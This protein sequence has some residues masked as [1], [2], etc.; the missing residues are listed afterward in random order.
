MKLI[1]T[2]LRMA[3]QNPPSPVRH[4]WCGPFWTV[5]ELENGRTG[6]CATQLENRGTHGEHP[7]FTR[8]AGR[9]AER[10]IDEIL[11]WAAEASGIERCIGLAALQ[12]SLPIPENAEWDRNAAD[13]IVMHSRKK[14]VA[15]VGWF[16]FL[17]HVAEA[18]ERV[19]VLERDPLTG[20]DITTEKQ[21][22]LE[23]CDMLCVTAATLGNDTLDAILQH[24]PSSATR[25]MV[26]PSTPVCHELLDSGWNGLYGAQ[27]THLS[28]VVHCLQEGG[29]F[30]QMRKTGGIRFLSL[31]RSEL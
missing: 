20:F 19:D 10:P 30:Q 24:V 14:R 31:S 8:T 7:Q 21:A 25:W 9:T 12:A 27:I 4:I 18:A 29:C 22:I 26:G 28:T 17:N 3:R 11:Q 1:H 23:S 15:M 2:L 5:A 13:D 6:L 16:P